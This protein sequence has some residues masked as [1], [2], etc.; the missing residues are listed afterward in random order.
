MLYLLIF[1]ARF[2]DY[3]KVVSFSFKI[4]LTYR[5]GTSYT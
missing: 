5:I 3:N 1:R 4:L 2:R